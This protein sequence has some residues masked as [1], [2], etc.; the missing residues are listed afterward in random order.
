MN[1]TAPTLLRLTRD[2]DVAINDSADAAMR[3]VVK[4]LVR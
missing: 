1:L 2:A 4:E 3:E